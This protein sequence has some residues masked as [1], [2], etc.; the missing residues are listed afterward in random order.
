MKKIIASLCLMV[1]LAGMFWEV[2]ELVTDFPLEGT[3]STTTIHDMSAD[4]TLQKA[5]EYQ[6][7]ERW[8]KIGNNV[9]VKVGSLL[10]VTEEGFEA[11]YGGYSFDA[12]LTG[13]IG[14]AVKWSALLMCFISG[15]YLYKL[16]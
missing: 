7:S 8:V 15:A 13:K 6:L 4:G 1:A 3:K 5:E 14:K 2:Y 10:K 9:R 12:P 16:K 11:V